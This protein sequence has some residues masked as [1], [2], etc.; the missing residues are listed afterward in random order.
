MLKELLPPIL[1][2]Y[3]SSFFYG[4][5]GNYKSWE[6]AQK[7]CSGY[8][9]E[10]IFNRV[11]NALLKVK[12]GEAVFE[13]DSVIFDKIQYSFPLLSALSQTA[14]HSSKKLSVLDFG[15]SMG[16]SYYQ[17]RK[18]FQQLNHFSWN[19]V[20]QKHFVEEGK[21]TFADETLKFYYTIDDCLSEQQ[22]NFFLLGSVLQYI[23][24]PYELLDII[25]SKK[26]TYIHID[27][28]P[29]FKNNNDRITIQKVPKSI[30]E[31]QYPC[32]I[33]NETKLINYIC[34][35]GYELVFDA[36]PIERINVTDAYL[37]GYYF[38]LK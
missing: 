14:L 35:A 11:K 4:W 7:K 23:E 30:Y 8:D 18:L 34:N 2:K 5:T 26:I 17:N 15:G 36:E 9:S 22:I 19:I 29:V 10:I 16:S 20:E 12:S 13:R 21:K 32:W 25:L 6:E 31:A 3:L 24:K 38:K 37:K 28:T 27:R 33:F 1:V